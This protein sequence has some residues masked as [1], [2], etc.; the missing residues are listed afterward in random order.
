MRD[1]YLFEDLKNNHQNPLSEL[2]PKKSTVEFLK[3][4]SKSLEVVKCNRINYD[5]ILN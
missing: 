5:I 4:Y 2:K 3:K 1:S